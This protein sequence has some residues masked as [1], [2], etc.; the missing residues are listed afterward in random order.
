MNECSLNHITES[1][2]PWLNTNH[3]RF[4]AIDKD[5]RVIFSFIDGVSRCR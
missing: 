2:E 3:I 5:S 4:I 1:L